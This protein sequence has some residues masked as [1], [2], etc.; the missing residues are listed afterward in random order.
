[1]SEIMESVK[2]IPLGA[3]DSNEQSPS[4]GSG[5][6]EKNQKSRKAK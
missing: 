4:G 1:M 5:P 6:S 2:E 3:K